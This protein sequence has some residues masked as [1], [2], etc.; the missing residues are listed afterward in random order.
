MCYT[1]RMVEKQLQTYERMQKLNYKIGGF[2]M[3]TFRV[4]VIGFN[5][6]V[7]MIN[8]ASYIIKWEHGWFDDRIFTLNAPAEVYDEI[9]GLTEECIEILDDNDEQ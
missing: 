9:S 4:N 7:F 1:G 3:R 2:V 8:Y 6:P 5:V